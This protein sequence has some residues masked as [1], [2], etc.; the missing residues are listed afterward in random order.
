MLQYRRSSE[1]SAEMEK[2]GGMVFCLI[3]FDLIGF[4]TVSEK[5]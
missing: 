5:V 4:L 3:Q 2:Y 1:W